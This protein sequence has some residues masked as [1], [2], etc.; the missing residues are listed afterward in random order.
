MAELSPQD[1]F[2]GTDN[3]AK[4]VD[5]LDSFFPAFIATPTYTHAEIMFRFG[6]RSV[7]EYLKSKL[8]T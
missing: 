2:K 3:L 5:E 6:Q 4:V 1:V 8:E 7:V